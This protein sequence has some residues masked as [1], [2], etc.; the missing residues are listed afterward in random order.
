MLVGALSVGVGG[1]GAAAPVVLRPSFSRVGS[2]TYVFAAGRYV[3]AGFTDGQSVVIDDRKGARAVFDH[4]GCWPEAFGGRWLLAQCGPQG[5]QA[6]IYSPASGQWRVLAQPPS[7]SGHPVA[8]GGD[9]VEFENVEPCTGRCRFTYVFENIDTGAVRR[10]AYREGGT[11]IPDLNSPGLA[12]RVCRPLRVPRGPGSLSFLGSFA[13]AEYGRTNEPTSGYLERCGTNLHRP[14]PVGDLGLSDTEIAGNATA[15]LWLGY[16]YLSSDH[17]ALHG[18]FLPSL[19]RF[20]IFLPPKIDVGATVGFV[21]VA[22]STKRLYV[23]DGEEQL[24]SAPAP[25]RRR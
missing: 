24:W 23:L 1:A 8:V 19:Q 10:I 25:M 17:P 9:W 20:T 18:L 7:G 12:R 6:A 14:V 2:A 16:G 11:T 4:P 21:Q 22:M 5:E 3:N 13:V 15:F